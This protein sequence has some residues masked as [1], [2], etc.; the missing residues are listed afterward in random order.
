MIIDNASVR[1][2][3]A[4][5]G[6]IAQA[7]RINVRTAMKQAIREWPTLRQYVVAGMPTGTRRKRWRKQARRQAIRQGTHQ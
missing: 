4:L 7:E 3:L 1:D 5:A 6:E 2:L